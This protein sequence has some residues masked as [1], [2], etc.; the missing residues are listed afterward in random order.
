MDI[1]VYF[2]DTTDLDVERCPECGSIDFEHTDTRIFCIRCGLVLHK[3]H[4]LT[5]STRLEE[6]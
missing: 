4:Y 6:V 3:S 5:A 1:E 2:S